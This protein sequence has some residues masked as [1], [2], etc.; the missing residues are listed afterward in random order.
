MTVFRWS[1]LHHAESYRDRAKKLRDA[2]GSTVRVFDTTAA[3]HAAQRP[4]LEWE[5]TMQ[6][7]ESLQAHDAQER[8]E[9]ARYATNADDWR[10]FK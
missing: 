9:V 1:P 4:L 2:G 5:K 8:V 6:Y 3:L 7:F 10:D